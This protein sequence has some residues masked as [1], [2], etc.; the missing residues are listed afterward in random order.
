MKAMATIAKI[1]IPCGI[2]CIAYTKQG[3]SVRGHLESPKISGLAAKRL[4]R[5]RSRA[6]SPFDNAFTGTRD[7]N[8]IYCADNDSVWIIFLTPSCLQCWCFC[9]V[10]RVI[11][12]DIASH[13]HRGMS[14]G[15]VRARAVQERKI[16]TEK[17]RTRCDDNT[18]RF[19]SRGDQA[20]PVVRCC[21]LRRSVRRNATNALTMRG[22][23]G[24]MIRHYV[25]YNN[26]KFL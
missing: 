15:T 14:M 24:W 4:S 18:I 20:R 13:S 10:S 5:A 21:V 3:I 6:V 19:R 23:D 25:W 7:V 1:T 16:R 26:T 22:A 9:N 11:R 12:R 8:T 17:L 2:R